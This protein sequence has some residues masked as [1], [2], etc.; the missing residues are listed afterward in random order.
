VGWP[1]GAGRFIG[2]AKKILPGPDG[3]G[4]FLAVVLEGGQDTA[5]WPVPTKVECFGK[6]WQAADAAMVWYCQEKGLALSSE[7]AAAVGSKEWKTLIRR[8]FHV[9]NQRRVVKALT[10]FA[11]MK[12]EAI[13]QHSAFESMPAATALIL[14]PEDMDLFE[15][16]V[17]EN[18]GLPMSEDSP[19][20]PTDSEEKQGS[21]WFLAPFRTLRAWFRRYIHI[22][23]HV[24]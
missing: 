2:Y 1:C 9:L 13:M 17:R 7:V 5:E 12:D 8:K 23:A 11:P 19:E 21:H 22:P 3:E 15:G 10:P 20:T 6:A 16:H 24:A 4:K 18:P 14:T